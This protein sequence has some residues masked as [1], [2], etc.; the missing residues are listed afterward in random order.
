MQT[1]EPYR[2]ARFRTRRDTRL[3]SSGVEG[4]NQATAGLN[5]RGPAEYTGRS[6]PSQP[7]THEEPTPPRGLLEVVWE[8]GGFVSVCRIDVHLGEPVGPYQGT[9]QG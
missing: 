4:G 2:S 3:A 8:L 9:A 1:V 6:L 5:Q 7:S